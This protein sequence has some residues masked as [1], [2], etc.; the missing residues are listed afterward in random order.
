MPTLDLLYHFAQSR[1]DEWWNVLLMTRP[2]DI[3]LSR[4]RSLNL[5]SVISTAV[6]Q[7]TDS[8]DPTPGKI[9]RLPL[10]GCAPSMEL[11]YCIALGRQPVIDIVGI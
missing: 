7:L 11:S 6:V 8:R 4:V 9:A 10:T 5:L 1:V 3:R 2:G